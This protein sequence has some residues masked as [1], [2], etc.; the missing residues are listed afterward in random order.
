MRVLTALA[1]ALTGV[2]RLKF[3]E[4]VSRGHYVCAPETDAGS[5]REFDE[6][7]LVGLYVFGHLLGFG[8]P[9]RHAGQ[10][11]CVVVGALRFD[12]TITDLFIIPPSGNT[13]EQ[14]SD[15]YKTIF[16]NPSSPRPDLSRVFKVH[17]PLGIIREDLILRLTSLS[18]EFAVQS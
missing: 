13:L 8:M 4:A 18:P 6:D 10:Y 9:P 12:P 15:D 1:V 11:A 7:D 16:L 3:N 2:S 14:V 5:S 17:F